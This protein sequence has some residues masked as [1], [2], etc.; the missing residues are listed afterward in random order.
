[1]E[2]GI[3]NKSRIKILPNTKVECYKD[4]SASIDE[5]FLAIDKYN[6]VSMDIEKF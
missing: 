1:M 5:V 6:F 3:G 4:D 2:M